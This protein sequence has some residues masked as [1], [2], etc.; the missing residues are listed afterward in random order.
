MLHKLAKAAR[1]FAYFD[2]MSSGCDGL[3]RGIF[4]RGLGEDAAHLHIVG[5]DQAAVADAFVRT[6][7]IQWREIDAG[8]YV[9]AGLG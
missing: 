9:S 7:V 3:Y 2:Q 1:V 6:S 4:D 5:E 8:L